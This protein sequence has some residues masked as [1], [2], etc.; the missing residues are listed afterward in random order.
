MKHRMSSRR[1]FVKWTAAAGGAGLLNLAACSSP[2]SAPEAK[3][4]PAAAPFTKELGAQLYTVRSVLPDKPKETLQAIAEIGYKEVEILQ[5]Q[6]DTL[7]PLLAELGLKPVSMHL[8]SKLIL[9]GDGPAASLAETLEKANS[10]GIGFVVMPY[11]PNESRGGLDVYRALAE[12]LNKAGQ[13]A[14]DAGLR[15]CYHN[16]AFEYEPMDGSTPLETL[17]TNCEPGL[18]ALEVDVFWVSVAGHDP[19]EMLR[20]YSGRAPLVHLKDKSPTTPQQFKEGLPPEH[21]KEV[22]NGTLDFVAILRAAA[23]T[24]VEHYFVEQ[25]QTPGDPVASLRQSY[26]YLR[27][28]EV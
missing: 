23:E 19:V 24:G 8:D 26:E 14:K 16:H 13:A 6:L 28:L 4:E 2:E 1:D 10:A 25:D 9:G 3:T 21:Y 17:M 15:L 5:A 22:G 27:S 20:T 11:V 12:K 7:P 18:V